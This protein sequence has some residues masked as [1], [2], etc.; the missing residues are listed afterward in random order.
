VGQ[1]DTD[2]KLTRDRFNKFEIACGR[3]EAVPEL[4]F[5]RRKQGVTDHLML[6]S[7]PPLTIETIALLKGVIEEAEQQLKNRK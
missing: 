5:A 1:T 4:L 2:K 7:G 6:L 3:M